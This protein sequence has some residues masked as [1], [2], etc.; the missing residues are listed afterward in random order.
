LYILNKFFRLVSG[1]LSSC[2]TIFFPV[3]VAETG[4][5]GSGK[6]YFRVSIILLLQCTA[7]IPSAGDTM[8]SDINIER[9]LHHLLDC[10][11]APPGPLPQ[12]CNGRWERLLAIM[13][14]KRVLTLLGPY[15][16]IIAGD[17]VSSLSMR[18]INTSIVT[19]KTRNAFVIRQTVELAGFFDQEGIPV[20]F[21]KGAAGLLRGLY[22][23]EER[24]LTDIDILIPPDAYDSA[25]AV[26]TRNGYTS[27]KTTVPDFH[28]HA[29]PFIHKDRVGEVEIH[30]EPYDL[31]ML[32]RPAMEHIWQDA[33]TITVENIPIAVPSLTDHAW[34]LMRSAFTE[35]VCFP[36]LIE[37]FELASIVRHS[38]NTLNYDVL[39]LRAHR[40]RIEGLLQSYSSSCDFYF[41][42]ALPIPF[43][44][45]HIER[46]SSWSIA[47]QK[48]YGSEQ[49]IPVY[50][51][52]FVFLMFIVD[53][54]ILSKIKSLRWL[55]RYEHLYD[56]LRLPH[57]HR[58]TRNSIR[59]IKDIGSY[60]YCR[61][62]FSLKNR[63]HA[64]D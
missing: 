23:P 51:K 12:R 19:N 44:P 54:D 4:Q 30:F 34:I 37:S 7:S 45:M 41:N 11:G 13:E 57:L 28:H 14:Q 48:S 25:V 63:D 58:I 47:L 21:L 52:R 2:Q 31:S 42:T 32:S 59:L 43:S 64:A 16:P 27:A 8:N 62:E 35:K 36:R 56:S 40:D 18:I 55:I 38:Q 24:V 49:K 29:T 33:D 26:L 17:A 15:L 1:D 9:I 53:H 6:Y 3:G 20:L 46:W 10:I 39:S 50:K 60:L 22:R 61:I 5:P